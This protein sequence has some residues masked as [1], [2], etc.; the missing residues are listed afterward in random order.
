M[1]RHVLL[2]TAMMLATAGLPAVSLYAT[3][4]KMSGFD[5]KEAL[6]S[7]VTLCHATNSATNPYVK[8]T[9]SIDAAG[10]FKDNGKG[11]H[12]QHTGPIATSETVAASLKGQH[13]SWG[14]II[15][16]GPYNTSVNWT[17]EGQVILNNDCHFPVPTQPEHTP[18][19]TPDHKPAPTP[20]PVTPQTPGKGDTTPPVQP[21]TPA[22]V[23]VATTATKTTQPAAT[24]AAALPYTASDHTFA[25]TLIAAGL[26]TIVTGIIIGVK[27]LYRHS[28]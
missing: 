4:G 18:C 8:I 14:D 26:A 6:T 9:V 5:M 16:A 15:P 21:Q 28:A 12:A 20:A 1:I 24:P 2:G 13:V 22:S 17:S 3:S 23:A 27:S 7:K 11:D 25:Y 10:T 19:P